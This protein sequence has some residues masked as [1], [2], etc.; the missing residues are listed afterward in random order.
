MKRGDVSMS[1]ASSTQPAAALD[2][3]LAVLVQQAV[4]GTLDDLAAELAQVVRDEIRRALTGHDQPDLV[5][6]DGWL[7]PKQAARV[8]GVSYD[9]VLGWITEGK[10]AATRVGR[11][12]RLKHDDLELF[13]SQPSMTEHVS[14]HDI[15]REATRI[16]RRCG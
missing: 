16:L 3:V 9:T 7:S 6:S 8:V 2:H 5:E 15:D 11:Q 14:E 10:L 4:S 12:L 1:P 13:M